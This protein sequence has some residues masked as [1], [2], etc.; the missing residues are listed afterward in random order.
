MLRVKGI[1]VI[2][3]NG[4]LIVPQ[5][6]R[7]LLALRAAVRRLKRSEKAQ[8]TSPESSTTGSSESDSSD[9]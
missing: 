5:S 4:S 7:S 9:G 1:R 3:E 8:G 2:P 6:L